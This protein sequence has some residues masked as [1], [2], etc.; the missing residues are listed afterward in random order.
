MQPGDNLSSESLSCRDESQLGVYTEHCSYERE[1]ESGLALLILLIF[2]A[3]VEVKLG[4]YLLSRQRY[5]DFAS[6]QVDLVESAD[7][8]VANEESYQGLLSKS[9]LRFGT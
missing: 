9:G 1:A 8:L 5:L 4:G 6:W 7:I 3:K 2:A